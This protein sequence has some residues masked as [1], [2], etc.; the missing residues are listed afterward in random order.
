MSC[1]QEAS[2]KWHH[3]NSY[4]KK[5]L[6]DLLDSQI[7][8]YLKYGGLFSPSP[9]PCRVDYFKKSNDEISNKA[10]EV[11]KHFKVT[12]IQELQ[13]RGQTPWYNYSVEKL[14]QQLNCSW[15]NFSPLIAS[16]IPII[17]YPSHVVLECY[18]TLL[19]MPFMFYIWYWQLENRQES[20]PLITEVD[21]CAKVHMGQHLMPLGMLYHFLTERFFWATSHVDR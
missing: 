3:Q 4:R 6:L 11:E 16:T 20:Q 10:K 1:K 17:L 12:L 2:W 5:Q 21:L 8:S 14:E 18:W 15:K 19:T 13:K 9:G 7:L